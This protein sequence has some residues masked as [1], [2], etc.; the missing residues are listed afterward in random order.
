MLLNAHTH[1]LTHTH[2]HTHTPHTFIFVDQNR[3]HSLMCIC[4]IF[5]Q[6]FAGAFVVFRNVVKISKN[7]SMLTAFKVCLNENSLNYEYTQ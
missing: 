6:I 7:M 4:K 2:T 3:V 5:A 1:T